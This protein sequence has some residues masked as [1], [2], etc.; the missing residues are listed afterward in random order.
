M[1]W[2]QV[3]GHG[4]AS[5][6]LGRRRVSR[7]SR[8]GHQDFFSR[9]EVGQQH[10]VQR[11]FAALGEQR[12][13]VFWYGDAVVVGIPQ[14]HGFAQFGQA[15]VGLV[16]ERSGALYVLDQRVQGLHRGRHVRAAD[17]Q[18]D[19]GLA[20]GL[21]GPD[22]SQLGGEVVRLAAFSSLRGSHGVG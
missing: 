22:L 14:A 6:Q 12:L 21:H 8:V 5:S 1:R 13:S 3:V 2:I 11:L 7:V 18:V 10:K 19:H 16:H 15:S 4:E 9:V 20:G 17:A